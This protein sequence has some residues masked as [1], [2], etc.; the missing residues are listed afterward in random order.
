M[1]TIEEL[2]VIAKAAAE[3]A[4]KD[5]IDEFGEPFFCGFA[6]VSIMFE[7]TNSKVATQFKAIGFQKTHI[8]KQLML[9]NPSGN[10]TQSM[11]PKLQGA[12]AYAEV[13]ISEGY[14]VYAGS[15]AD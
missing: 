5:Y 1:F 11:D 10:G 12:V 7:R 13:F 15:R 14:E 4:A 9:W 3:K 8:P 6:W 2:H